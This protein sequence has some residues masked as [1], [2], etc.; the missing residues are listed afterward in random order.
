MSFSVYVIIFYRIYLQK[1]KTTF[2]EI[3]DILIWGSLE[4]LPTCIHKLGV[5]KR[6]CT[7][8]V[9]AQGEK[10]G[11]MHASVAPWRGRQTLCIQPCVNAGCVCAGWEGRVTY[12]RS[13]WFHGGVEWPVWFRMWSRSDPL[14]GSP[15]RSRECSLECA[16]KVIPWRALW[17]RPW[18]REGL[19][20]YKH[21]CP[22]VV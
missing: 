12:Q 14:E 19:G 13:S 7:Q 20:F 16:P 10:A 18:E 2:G 11:S 15:C 22:S 3:H 6:V 8:G 9:Y 4:K 17:D 1:I 21:W 5:C